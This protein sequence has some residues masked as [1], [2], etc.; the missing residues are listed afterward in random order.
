MQYQSIHCNINVR[1][2]SYES[3]KRSWQLLFY[4]YETRRRIPKWTECSRHKM[5]EAPMQKRSTAPSRL[6]LVW[7][8]RFYNVVDRADHITSIFVVRWNLDVVGP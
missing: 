6:G 5:K 4:R 2:K 3:E 8:D 1:R 7:K